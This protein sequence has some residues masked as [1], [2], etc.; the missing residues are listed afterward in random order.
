MF[1][2]IADHGMYMATTPQAMPEDA[3]NV[4]LLMPV[5]VGKVFCDLVET[6]PVKNTDI[7]ERVN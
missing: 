1:T 6:R 4:Q 3:R 5:S 2:A 7:N